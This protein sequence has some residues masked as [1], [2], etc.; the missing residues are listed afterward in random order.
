MS[1]FNRVNL[2]AQ[3]GKYIGEF[4]VV[5]VADL[6]KWETQEQGLPDLDKL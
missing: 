2:F 6:K 5:D 3:L 4:L 1:L